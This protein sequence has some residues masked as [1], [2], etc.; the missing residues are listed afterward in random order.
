LL[1]LTVLMFNLDARSEETDIKLCACLL[2][3]HSFPCTVPHG[4]IAEWCVNPPSR[5]F[6]GTRY[7]CNFCGK[8]YGHHTSLMHHQKV[9]SGETTCVICNKVLN[10]IFDLK[11]HLSFVHGIND[12]NPEWGH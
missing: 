4:L 8:S 2:L 7:H 10:R 9:H 3:R 11:M 6:T 1:P 5:R 12:S